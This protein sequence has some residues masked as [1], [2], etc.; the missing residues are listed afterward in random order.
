MKKATVRGIEIAYEDV[1]AGP[2]V[3]CI[4]GFPLSHELWTPTAEKLSGRYRLIMPDLRG[5]GQSSITTN[6]SMADH[7]D[8]LAALLDA[9][10]VKG[11][12]NVM[13]LSMGGYIAFELFRRHPQRVQSLVLADTQA[14]SDTAE[15]A[16][17]RRE[18]AEKVLSQGVEFIVDAM[19]PN[20]FAPNASKVVVNQ[21]RDIMLAS[22][23]HGVAAALHALADRIDSAETF[24]DIHVPTFVVVGEL[25]AITPPDVAR[26]MSD[27]IANASLQVIA[28][29]GHMS[30]VEAPDEFTRIVG[31]FLDAS[32]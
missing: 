24:S 4:H 8:D 10:N 21:W 28:G 16:R 1:G 26:V 23:P 6:A 25:D 3:L 17:G 19:L 14:A 31:E 20:L 15:K 12:V 7:A 13:A 9:I 2:V 32:M 5:L 27:G 29:V 11:A 22:D 18:T 30:P